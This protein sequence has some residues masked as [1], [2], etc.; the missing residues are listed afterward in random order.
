V[1]PVCLSVGWV[2]V[3]GRVGWGF[4]GWWGSFSKASKILLED[5]LHSS[6][7]WLFSENSFKVPF[8][9]VE[10]GLLL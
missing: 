1:G 8:Y 10:M 5:M 9:G 2:L 4:Y 6:F 3:G 7:R